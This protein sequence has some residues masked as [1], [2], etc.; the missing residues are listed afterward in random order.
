MAD[1]IFSTSPAVYRPG[2]LSDYTGADKEGNVGRI[3]INI[4]INQKNKYA[5]IKPYTFFVI[6]TYMYTNTYILLP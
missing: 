3:N 2:G 4:I 1:T 5:M 6:S